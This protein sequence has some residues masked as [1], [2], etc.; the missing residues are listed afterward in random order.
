MSTLK[1]SFNEAIAEY[2]GVPGAEIIDIEQETESS[3]YCDTCW[4]EYIVVYVTYLD[5]DGDRQT[6]TY[7]GNMA[8]WIQELTA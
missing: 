5:E 6:Y 2:M 3:G 7:R 1:I 4:S 8:E